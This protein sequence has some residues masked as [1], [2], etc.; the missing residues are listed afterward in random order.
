LCVTSL[1][2]RARASLERGFQ[3]REENYAMCDFLLKLMCDR[4]V[5]LYNALYHIQ[6]PPR[7][8]AIASSAYTPPTSVDGLV[9]R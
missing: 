1:I 7:C 4:S 2:A 5:P 8:L 9:R 3:V 6:P